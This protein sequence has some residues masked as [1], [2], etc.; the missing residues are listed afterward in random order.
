MTDYN[1]SHDDD[2][3]DDLLFIG[4]DSTN[5]PYFKCSGDVS[6]TEPIRRFIDYLIFTSST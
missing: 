5:V 4:L 6:M 2:Y 3:D 1:D